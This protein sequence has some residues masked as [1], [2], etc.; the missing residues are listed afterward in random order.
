MRFAAFATLVLLPRLP[1]GDVSTTR[2]AAYLDGS[3]FRR[4][5][6][7]EALIRSLDDDRVEA[8]E[9]AARRLLELGDRALPA[10]KGSKNPEARALVLRI[11]WEPY[12]P[13]WLADAQPNLVA[14]LGSEADA[15]SSAAYDEI[16]RAGAYRPALEWK[17]IR[18]GPPGLRRRALLNLQPRDY[19]VRRAGIL[20]DALLAWD[21][22]AHPLSTAEL[23]PIAGAVVTSARPDQAGRLRQLAERLPGSLGRVGLFGLAAIGDPGAKKTAVA[24]LREA[25]DWK[26][27]AAARA[28][29]RSLD[30]AAAAVVRELL[31]RRDTTSILAGLEALAA[32]PDLDVRGELAAL[33]SH[34]HPAVVSGALR[35][36]ALRKIDVVKRLWELFETG[37]AKVTADRDVA[38]RLGEALL[39]PDDP[40]ILDRLKE[41][42]AKRGPMTPILQAA[43]QRVPPPR[44]EARLRSIAAG[45]E[46]P[47]VLATVGTVYC[48]TRLQRPAMP[49]EVLDLL[50]QI[51]HRPH[52]PDLYTALFYVTCPTAKEKERLI[53]LCRGWL[54]VK[55]HPMRVGAAMI[56]HRMRM[57][58]GHDALLAMA[59]EGGADAERC[60]T[61]LGATADTLP[62]LRERLNHAHPTLAL[63]TLSRVRD[64]AVIPRVLD[65]IRKREIPLLGGDGGLAGYLKQYPDRDLTDDL[66]ALLNKST[67]PAHIVSILSYLR[68]KGRKDRA[69]LVRPYLTHPYILVQMEA[70]GA[71]GEWG[72]RE[73]FDT[74]AGMLRQGNQDLAHALL[75]ALLRIDRERA[76]SHLRQA[77]GGPARLQVFVRLYGEISGPTD[78][79]LIRRILQTDPSAHHTLPR[80]AAPAVGAGI[81]DALLILA[82]EGN[83]DAALGLAYLGDRRGVAAIADQLE[84]SLSSR[85]LNALDLLVHADR[86]PPP[87]RKR[88]FQPR[89]LP[90][91]EAVKQFREAFGI[92]LAMPG[93]DGPPSWAFAPEQDFLDCLEN[94]AGG[95]LRGR[96]AHL[97]RN[98]RVELVPVEEALAYWKAWWAN[99]AQDYR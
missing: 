19:G 3:S 54:E 8:R 36:I 80:V 30:P 27:S 70:A 93:R 72:D 74:M 31:G 42:L 6:D 26:L 13:L 98:D 44:V 92:E 97:W 66:L 14:Q 63:H 18:D 65:L 99:H 32:F 67:L 91:D 45:K 56:L 90:F 37:T 86:F 22:K 25:A 60:L 48:R 1:G 38:L 47:G 84:G 57:K 71:L 28:L 33:L 24:D 76:L 69:A 61:L 62:L 85:H 51:G 20:L 7:V 77:L 83:A 68:W 96:F 49:D 50:E 2:M 35:H 41:L 23:Q 75:M 17:V 64:E 40:A 95:W 89:N 53:R 58:D 21:V 34:D 82:E 94:G 88:T 15:I 46:G 5:D 4:Q 73:S 10:L 59:R 16:L 43:V 87:A 78:A 52:F 81:A 55:D 79:R 39:V 9:E 12:V 11:E 29:A